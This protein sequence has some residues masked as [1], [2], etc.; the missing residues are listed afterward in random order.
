MDRIKFANELIAT[1]MDDPELRKVVAH[2]LTHTLLPWE[3]PFEG[4]WSRSNLLGKRIAY[5]QR[6]AL[7]RICADESL[8]E[9][10][11]QLVNE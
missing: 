3:E 10:G 1:L 8:I 5:N 9:Q 4:C 7:D 6:T 11:Y 2:A